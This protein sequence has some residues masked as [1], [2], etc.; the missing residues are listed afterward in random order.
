MTVQNSVLMDAM[1]RL[2]NRILNHLQVIYRDLTQ[3]QL[4]IHCDHLIKSMNIKEE[5]L[6]TTT[7][8]NHWNQSDIAVITYGDSIKKRGQAPLKTLKAFLDRYADGLMNIVHILPFFPWSSDDGFSVMDYKSVNESL[9]S[10][11]DIKAISSDYDLMSDLVINHCS[12]RSIWFTNFLK[13]ADPG[14]EYFFTADSGYDLTQ[15]VRPRTTPLLKKVSTCQGDKHVWCTFGEDQIDFNFK[16]PEVIKEF[17][18]II[19]LYLDNGV[20]IFRLD[21]VAFLWKVPGTGC[22]GL[23]ETHEII[24]LFRTLFILAVIHLKMYSLNFCF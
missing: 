9:G 2:R 12:S 14:R 13:N 24:R 3:D 15:V 22:V 21:A 17:V 8:K 10:W 4:E 20:R 5:R 1:E 18:K 11:N 6:N 19:K 23:P 16:N 7:R